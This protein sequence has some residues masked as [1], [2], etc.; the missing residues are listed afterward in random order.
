MLFSKQ[1]CC[2]SKCHCITNLSLCKVHVQPSPP[3]KNVYST[4]DN[5]QPYLC[6]QQLQ[7]PRQQCCLHCTYSGDNLTQTVQCCVYQWPHKHTTTH[8]YNSWHERACPQL[9]L[10]PSEPAGWLWLCRGVLACQSQAASGIGCQQHLLQL[11]ASPQPQIPGH[12]ALMED[13]HGSSSSSNNRTNDMKP[14][15]K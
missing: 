15:L 10:S 4:K 2:R 12:K 11:Q 13:I 6:Q 1:F 3:E 7:A 8:G 5:Q 14:I 9:Q